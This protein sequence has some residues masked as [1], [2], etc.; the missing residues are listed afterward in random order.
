[1]L[2]KKWLY[3]LLYLPAIVNIFVFSLISNI[4]IEQ[5]NLVNTYAGWVNVSRNTFWDWLYNFYYAGFSLAGI[6]LILHWG[7][8]SKERAIKKQSFILGTSYAVAILAG[9]MTEFFIN[10]FFS[11]KVPQV[12]PIIILIPISF[13]LYCIKLY[14][15]MAPV[16]K[17][18]V[19][20]VGQILSEATRSR[21]YQYLT[22]A[23]I[24]G[25][26]I[27]FAIQYFSN[28]EQ[29]KSVLLFSTIMFLIGLILH[30]VQS[31]KIRTDLRD[32][33]SNL[34]MTIS[35]PIMVLKYIDY[36]AI[37]AWAVPVIFVLVS[38]AFNQSRILTLIG[39][40]TILTFIWI[41]IIEP[42][43]IVMIE[44]IDHVVRICIFLI[45]LWIAHFINH[46]YLQRLAENEEQVKLQKLLSHI[47]TIFAIANE[48]NIGDKINEMLRLCG[49]HFKADRTY[50]FFPS[51]GEKTKTGIYEWHG[52]G[53]ESIS[54]IIGETSDAELPS[55]TD[56]EQ[57]LHNGG[58]SIP[59]AAVMSETKPE[60]GW[61]HDMYINSLI[62]NPLRD[63]DTVIGCIGFETVKGTIIWRAEHQ[64][65]LKVLAN[66]ISD[67]WLKVE[68]EKEI[69]Y[70]AY[71][72]T[73]TGLPNRTLLKNRLEQSIDQAIRTER[74]V[75]LIFIDIDSFKSVNDAMGHNGGD[76]LLIQITQRLSGYIRKDDT[77]ARFGGDE[78]IIMVSQA[79]QPEEIQKVADRIMEAF[80]QPLIVKDQEFFINISAGIAV[81]PIDGDETEDLIKKADMAMYTSKEKGRNRYTFYSTEM[82]K[83]VLSS[84]E[85]TSSLY[86][87]Q[88]Q[89]EFVLHYQPQISVTTGKIIGL[90]AL[91][92][93]QHPQK[94]MIPPGEF[95]PIAEKTGLINPIGQWV[96]EAACRQSKAWQAK[97]LPPTKVAVN[98][99]V[100]QLRNPNLSEIVRDVLQKTEL[101][102]VYLELE[103]TESLGVNESEYIISTL[104]KLKALGVSI[105]IDDFGTEYSS[106]SRLKILPIDRI[107]IDMQFIHGITYGSKDEGI[108]KVILRLGSI[109]GI[110]VM[111]EGVENE[112]QLA[113]LKENSCDEIQGFYF[114]KPM[115]ADEVELILRNGKS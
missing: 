80:F 42:V 111:A 81:F 17:N 32:G 8:S 36:S 11:I 108:I 5:Y 93:W 57:L 87:A 49:E 58:I 61:L 71:Y 37:Y 13:I 29:L 19:A 22:I 91:I 7:I 44:S 109:L 43:S 79:S 15:L 47:S 95:I 107:K 98:L 110:N 52:A 94:G 38:V 3:I 30:L 1:M 6:G 40:T 77:L 102:P 83:D 72:D 105:S 34:V 31:L 113:F 88:S 21:L 2:Q 99:S 68:A 54:D 10:A 26:F 16:E 65:T 67:I 55:R 78:F 18:Q 90:E 66:L 41:W 59:E 74:L 106:F 28:R 51:N 20:D 75:G 70:M 82:E 114:Y 12:A 48:S 76:D 60:R 73:L 97:G 86:R 100:V 56:L 24:L 101:D 23:Y 4:A 14:G 84:M 45:V 33:L 85:L 53:I 46:V 62:V 104:N 96:L 115:P 39:T 64:A 89:N 9:T 35:I 92:R 50:L 25:A 69:R 112:Q 103:I 63:K 27:S